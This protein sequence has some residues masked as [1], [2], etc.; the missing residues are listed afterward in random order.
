M[1]G[2]L[3]PGVVGRSRIVEVHGLWARTA[4]LNLNPN[5]NPNRLF[6]RR[7]H[8]DVSTTRFGVR[9]SGKGML[10]EIVAMLVGWIRSNS[11]SRDV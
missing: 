11:P 6:G 10:L 4:V 8:G 2:S 1:E 5:L 3:G 9:L 7:I